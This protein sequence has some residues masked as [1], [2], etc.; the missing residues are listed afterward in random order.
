MR[1]DPMAEAKP[2]GPRITEPQGRL[3]ALI[4]REQPVTAYQLFKL[5]EMSPAD[6]INSSKGQ[7]YPAIARLKSQGLVSA[8]PVAG[9][10][11]N[12][13]EL[14]VTKQGLAEVRNWARRADVSLVSI[15]DCLRARILSFDL[16]TREE[17]LEWIARAKAA[18][19]AKAEQFDAYRR[20][21]DVRHP[22][23]DSMFAAADAVL[24][25]QMGW[26]DD[27]LY[28]VAGSG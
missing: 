24:R 14:T 16:L 13:E 7:I 12:A 3:L 26:L 2:S 9:D 18:V 8:R 4:A 19:K 5:H 15:D 28:R 23:A 11:R 21:G 25:A 6:S 10:G 27:L 1:D 17:R 22:F 20:S